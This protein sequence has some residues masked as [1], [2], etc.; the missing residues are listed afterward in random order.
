M[1]RP[2]RSRSRVDERALA[3]RAKKENGLRAFR[4]Q[5][6]SQGG[7]IESLIRERLL[8]D[9][10]PAFLTSLFLD[11]RGSRERQFGF[12]VDDRER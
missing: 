5:S 7:G 2:V 3:G 1:R 12:A 8:R 6:R 4:F 11:G 10:G 9:R